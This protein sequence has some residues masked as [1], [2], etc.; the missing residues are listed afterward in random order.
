MSQRSRSVSEDDALSWGWANESVAD[1][2]FS[3]V[4]SVTKREPVV[5]LKTV[6]RR[7]LYSTLAALSRR[8]GAAQRFAAA[9]NM[10]IV[11]QLLS[12][13]P[14]ELGQACHAFLKLVAHVGK[15]PQQPSSAQQPALYAGDR[16]RQRSRQLDAY[17]HAGVDAAATPTPF[18]ASVLRATRTVFEDKLRRLALLEDSLADND[19]HA[20]SSLR[21]DIERISR[22]IDGDRLPE[23]G[24]DYELSSGY[25]LRTP[26]KA[27]VNARR[28]DP[29]P[30]SSAETHRFMTPSSLPL[31][32][33]GGSG[34]GYES[35]PSYP[36]SSGGG[37]T[38]A[39]AAVH[40]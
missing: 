18:E 30:L 35:D 16:S 26:S 3:E 6:H 13:S 21:A 1:D 12:Q 32:I 5:R 4:Q 17:F 10:D 38:I 33:T 20:I 15:G 9:S 27:A 29:D 37:A 7:S 2:Q 8:A 28:V 24:R 19:V 22:R 39:V 36:G 11:S 34:R 31:S 14:T 23:S 40:I 25:G